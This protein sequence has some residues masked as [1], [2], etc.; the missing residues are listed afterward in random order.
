MDS[1][2]D[3]QKNYDYITALNSQ[4]IIAYNPRGS[5][6]PPE[7][8]NDRFQP[9]CSMGYELTYWGKD[10]NYLKFRC[11][12]ATGKINCPY[13]MNWCSNSYYG[14]CHKVNYKEN[15]R[16]FSYPHRF[17]NKFQ[18]IIHNYKN[19][20]VQFPHLNINRH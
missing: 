17:L 9:I 10:G 12:H 1:G 18:E 14:Y 19:L 3:F 20:I 4:V 16:Y 8:L 6:A 15:N 7:G 2:Y 5:Y 11:P 13:G